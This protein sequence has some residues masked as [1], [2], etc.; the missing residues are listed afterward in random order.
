MIMHVNELHSSR[1]LNPIGNETSLLLENNDT[2]L[3]AGMTSAHRQSDGFILSI[4]CFVILLPCMLAVCAQSVYCAKKRRQD[5]IDR[6]LLA[7]STNP[8]SRM[9]VLSEIFKNDIRV[10]EVLIA[11]I[12]RATRYRSDDKL[13]LQPVTKDEA[14][15]NKKKSVLVKKHRKKTPLERQR[16]PTDGI[17]MNLSNEAFN[18]DDNTVRVERYQQSNECDVEDQMNETWWDEDDGSISD[19]EKP[20]TVHISGKVEQA[21]ISNEEQPLEQDNVSN[22]DGEEHDAVDCE[23]ERRVPGGATFEMEGQWIDIQ[24][25]AECGEGKGV[26]GSIFESEDEDGS[27]RIIENAD[28]NTDSMV[29]SMTTGLRHDVKEENYKSPEIMHSVLENLDSSVKMTESTK[30]EVSPGLFTHE[31]TSNRAN[32]LKLGTSLKSSPDVTLAKPNNPLDMPF[33]SAAESPSNVNLSPRALSPQTLFVDMTTVDM[34][35]EPVI[36]GLRSMPDTND[37]NSDDGDARRTGIHSL[38]RGTEQDDGC[39]SHVTEVTSNIDV[40]EI[41]GWIVEPLLLAPTKCTD[42]SG[43]SLYCHLS[44]VNHLGEAGVIPMEKSGNNNSTERSVVTYFSYEDISI[45]SEESEM[46]AICLCAYEEGDRRIFSKRCSHGELHI[47]PEYHI[48]CK[49]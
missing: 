16:R 6:Q 4:V 33:L 42:I 39:G 32:E 24:P 13:N 44:T 35:A 2:S 30:T 47:V 34:T 31:K 41:G 12:S 46:C 8:T 45:A 28:F 36:S 26:G 27:E 23:H 14:Y 11:I 9:L 21:V 18:P 10:S 29:S 48:R 40:K 37:D 38:F 49:R 5:R 7:V 15:A 22:L 25:D 17:N 1:L 3:S 19:G 20:M 43:P